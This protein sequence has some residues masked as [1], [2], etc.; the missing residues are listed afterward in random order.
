R[1]IGIIMVI[2]GNWDVK[3][4]N[5][6]GRVYRGFRNQ[7]DFETEV[8]SFPPE[9]ADQRIGAKEYPL[10]SSSKSLVGG[11]CH[12]PSVL[13]AILTEKPYPVKANWALNDL[14]LCLEGSEETREALKRLDFLVGSDFFMTPTM[15][16]CDLVLPPHFYPEKEGLEYFMYQDMVAAKERVIPPVYDTMDDREMDFE[17]ARRM[18]LKLPWRTVAELQNHA[19]RDTG[20]TFEELKER[21]FITQT[22]GYKKYEKTGFKTPSG[23]VELY[24]SL[25]KEIG[26]DDPLPYYMEG[27]ETPFSAQEIARDYPLVLITGHRST[28]YFHSSHRQVPWCREL[29]PYPRIQIHPETASGLDIKDGDW[30]WIEAPKDRGRVQMKAEVTR[31]VDPRVV[32]VPS[33]WWYPED[34]ENPL[35]GWLDSNI[36]RII[37]NDG[38]YDRISGAST[39]RG[40]L[41]KV[42]KVESGEKTP[43]GDWARNI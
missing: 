35:H 33:H 42:Y 40:L 28:A 24:A 37:T 9:V 15:E 2:C 14:M 16:M 22:T 31:K 4:G 23:K 30:V 12:P 1:A 13:H 10:F 43:E 41:C 26:K 21:K 29:E 25:T 36:N 6:S 19:L 17:V 5:I 8:L 7:H 32:A 3:G 34:T 38:P 20:I 11:V 18:G 39:L 27:H